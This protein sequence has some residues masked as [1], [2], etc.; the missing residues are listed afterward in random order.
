MNKRPGNSPAIDQPI[1]TVMVQI[2]FEDCPSQGLPICM[3]FYEHLLLLLL[4]PLLLLLL[5]P[6]LLLLT[7]C[8]CADN[9]S[10]DSE[11]GPVRSAFADQLSSLGSDSTSSHSTGGESSVY[12][13]YVCTVEPNHSVTGGC[14]V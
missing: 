12:R 4:Q 8:V 9:S 3:V 6:L 13:G 2:R 1:Q 11:T 7:L 10:T 14:S 5:Q